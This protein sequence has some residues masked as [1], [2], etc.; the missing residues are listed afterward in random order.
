MAEIDHLVVAARDLDSGAA[1]LEERLGAPLVPGGTHAAMGTHNRLLRLEGDEG[2]YLELIAIDPA[3]PAPG[4][5]RWFGLD[6]PALQ[7]RLAL[8][9]HLVHWVARSD[10]LAR[11]ALPAHGGTLAMQRGSYSWRV[12]VTPDGQPPGAGLV[13]TLIQWDVPH[14]PAA[15]LPSSGCTLMK[16]EGFHPDPAAIAT[17]AADLEKLG[18]ARQ[19][20]L[21]PTEPGEAPQLVAYLRTP[22]GLV[23]LD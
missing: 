16:L 4:R 18:L 3:A 17:I 5:P 6:D 7:A 11:E 20:A 2:L 9:P 12:T 8:R 1:W 21:F 22:L 19:L 23:E 13:P 10:D 14:N 15:R